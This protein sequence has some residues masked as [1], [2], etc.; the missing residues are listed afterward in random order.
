MGANSMSKKNANESNSRNNK[1][2]I[3]AIT[4]VVMVL[5]F[6]YYRDRQMQR[7][8]LLERLDMQGDVMEEWGPAQRQQN[9]TGQGNGKIL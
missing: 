9:S 4:I 5:I 7:E 6:M 2:I 1:G 8:L 3:I